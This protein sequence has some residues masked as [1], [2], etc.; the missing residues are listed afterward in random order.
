VVSDALLIGYL[1]KTIRPV[2]G[3]ARRDLRVGLP[4]ARAFRPAQAETRAIE[5]VAVRTPAAAPGA[6]M[7]AVERHDL[8]LRALS[9]LSDDERECVALRFGADLKL[10]DIAAA[11]GGSVT[12]T[13][14]LRATAV[15]FQSI[16]RNRIV[17]PG[18]NWR[19]QAPGRPGT[20]EP[21]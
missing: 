18:A 7:D 1:F 17:Q 14:G 16:D 13:E 11:I 6:G 15:E 4:R 21:S 9:V 3:H 19:L 12:T 20:V 5:R 2:R 10:E 8:V